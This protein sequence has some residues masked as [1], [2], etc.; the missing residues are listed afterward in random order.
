[1]KL[2]ADTC[3]SLTGHEITPY[4]VMEY[5]AWAN[6][7]VLSDDNE[8]TLLRHYRHGIDDYVLEIVGC[9][10]DEGETPEG[11]MRRELEE[12]VG[13]RGATIHQTG[14][15]YANPSTQTNKNFCF[16][17]LGGTFD[18]KREDEPGADFQIVK[19]PL[20]ELLS[21][22]ENQSEVLQSLHLSSIFLALNYLKNHP[23]KNRS[24]YKSRQ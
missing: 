16:I 15:C 24:L 11:A 21:I 12:E 7:V 18:G 9:I 20:D 3:I 8:I 17:A 4:Y 2:R 1:M 23:R 6:C 13:L 22:I 14:A 10:V 19:M 5:G